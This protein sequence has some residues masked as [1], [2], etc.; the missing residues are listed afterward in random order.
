MTA[1][2]SLRK[3]VKK[4][5]TLMV[6]VPWLAEG[7]S[8]YLLLDI[9][10]ALSPSHKIIIILTEKSSNPLTA[11][12]KK[13]TKDILD[14]SDYK[15]PK[16][17]GSIINFLIQH[18][19]VS[20]ILTS[21]SSIFYS[22]LAC[23]EITKK[24]KIFSLLHNDFRQGHF[25]HA[26]KADKYIYKHIC[27]SNSIGISLAKL[28]VN[29]K[30]IAVINNGVSS[31]YFYPKPSSK[32]AKSRFNLGIK[33]NEVVLG[34]VGRASAEKNPILFLREFHKVSKKIP[35]KA[36][37]ISSGPLEDLI[38]IFI[39]KHK[40]EQ[41]VIWIKSIKRQ[42]LCSLYNVFDILVNCSSIEGLPLTIIESL[43][44]GK[45]FMAYRI[46]G[47]PFLSNG[48]NSI[49]IAKT[50]K[51]FSRDLIKILND[52]PKIVSMQAEAYRHFINSN[53]DFKFM[54]DKYKKVFSS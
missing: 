26:V 15:S 5:T 36:I 35:A 46:G 37:L 2:S 42:E 44:C 51:C 31:R 41:K 32:I 22:S 23:N 52:K 40:I 7:G 4:K 9:L 17:F 13:L 6:I 43:A 45:P 29:N 28:G 18:L 50:N 54:I 16:N 3:I 53:L 12:F 30:K 25:K 39:K 19:H 38:A 20:K 33:K 21:N 1:H 8:E 24:N 48:S 49:L 11:H 47:I 27:I 14:L 10:T 34:F